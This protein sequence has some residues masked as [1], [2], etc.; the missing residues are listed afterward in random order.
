MAFFLNFTH[1]ILLVMQV[2]SR[3]FFPKTQQK[4]ACF[5]AGVI[6]VIVKFCG[7]QPH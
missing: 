3:R 4:N 1:K 7:Q 2:F 6:M 5:S